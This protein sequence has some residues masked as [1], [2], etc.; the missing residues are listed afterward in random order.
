[1][2]DSGMDLVALSFAAKQLIRIKAV[3]NVH[4]NFSNHPCYQ[5]ILL[6][7]TQIQSYEEAMEADYAAVTQNHRKCVTTCKNV[8]S[9]VLNITA[10]VWCSRL[11]KAPKLPPGRSLRLGPYW[12]VRNTADFKRWTTV[13]SFTEKSLLICA[14]EAPTFQLCCLRTQITLHSEVQTLVLSGGDLWIWHEE[15]I[16]IL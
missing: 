1:M 15:T 2:H 9:W 5:K 14:L 10:F 11:L 8:W 12:N 4:R 13:S 3:W 16:H 7:I 6:F